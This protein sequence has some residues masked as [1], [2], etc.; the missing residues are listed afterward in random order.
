M[1]GSKKEPTK[2]ETAL[3]WLASQKVMV[4][5]SNGASRAGVAKIFSQLGVKSA[6]LLLAECYST[7]LELIKSHKPEVIV[8][9]FDFGKASGLTLLQEQR[10]SN[11]EAARKSLFVI[12]TGNASQS[13]VAE[14][15]EEDVDTFIL[16]PYTID[17]FRNCLI[18]AINSKIAVNPYFDAID[19]GKALLLA[20]KPEEALPH[21]EKAKTLDPKPSLA[22]F[23]AGQAQ[24]TK[25]LLEGAEGDFKK[26][27]T[28]NKIH[29]KCMVGLFDSL[30]ERKCYAEAY[31][32]IQQL[33]LY[34]P[35]NPKRLVTIIR[36][37]I[38]NNKVNDMEKYHQIFTNLENRSP[39]LIK[40]ICA[41]LVVCGKQHLKAGA[42]PQAMELFQ[43]AAISSS[44]SPKFLREIIF[45]LAAN[46]NFAEAETF[47]KRFP[48]DTRNSADFLASDLLLVNDTLPPE[49]TVNRGRAAIRIG[50]VDP[51]I[52]ET[53]IKAAV[54]ANLKRY[55]EELSL[56]AKKIWPAMAA[57][58]DDIL[59]SLPAKEKPAA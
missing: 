53:V 25:K 21:F 22:C 30:M 9:D 19:A 47:L 40:T 1:A 55:A 52:H 6:N 59:N 26:G 58:V 20:G 4:A 31:D 54:R 29:Y 35:A 39:E 51:W 18:R 11:P 15:A 5:D 13:A 10:G 32:V 50:A 16:K 44:G 3:A 12:V 36:L 45:A 14:A 24:M 33:S 17:T 38:M 23:Y 27:L 8:T 7:A 41:G 56:E 48:A 42:I 2:D 37:A 28:F 34:F 49:E 57:K 46:K 43:K